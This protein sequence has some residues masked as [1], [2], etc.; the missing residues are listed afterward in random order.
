MSQRFSL[1]ADLSVR[2]NLR[3]YGHIYGL[4]PA[5]LRRRMDDVLDLTGIGDRL[6]QLG[7]NLSG[8]WKQRLALACALI[9]ECT[10]VPP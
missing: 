4:E 9:H 8:G 6:D 1:Y 2:E 7:G 3:F 5:R 10:R